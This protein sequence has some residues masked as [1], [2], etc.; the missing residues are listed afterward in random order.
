M[1]AGCY[2]T[3]IGFTVLLIAYAACNG[4]SSLI[5]QNSWLVSAEHDRIIRFLVDDP[6]IVEESGD[7]TSCNGNSA[8]NRTR[9]LFC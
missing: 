8:V 4:L 6:K 2:H 1:G 5:D 9:V 3:E 7:H